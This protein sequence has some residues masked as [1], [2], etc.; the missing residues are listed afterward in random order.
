MQH[1]ELK[2][3]G[4]IHFY[5]CLCSVSP[6]RLVNSTDG[7][8]AVISEPIKVSGK[9]TFTPKAEAMMTGASL[10]QIRAKHLHMID[11]ENEKM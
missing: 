11:Y 9:V 5:S 8:F 7:V 1:F 4:M 10:P 6:T 3:S 2:T